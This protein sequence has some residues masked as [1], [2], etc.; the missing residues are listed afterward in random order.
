MFNRYL[1][2]PKVPNRINKV[3]FYPGHSLTVEISIINLVT[4]DL[5]VQVNEIEDQK[6]TECSQELLDFQT[7]NYFIKN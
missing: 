3:N 5:F 6:A 7:E 1:L 2:K 4:W